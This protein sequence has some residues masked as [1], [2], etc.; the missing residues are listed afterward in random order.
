MEKNRNWPFFMRLEA[1]RGILCC[2]S[3]SISFFDQPAFSDSCQLRVGH[4]I[5]AYL[6]ARVFSAWHNNMR[7]RKDH[8]KK[9]GRYFEAIEVF[10]DFENIPEKG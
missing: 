8:L 3:L 1:R 4:Q 5:L 6:F 9:L 2:H 10:E 7:K